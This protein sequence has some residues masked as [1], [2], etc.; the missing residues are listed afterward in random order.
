MN[1]RFTK[2]KENK[3]KYYYPDCMKPLLAV[4]YTQN[5]HDPMMTFELDRTFSWLDWRQAELVETRT[6][7]ATLMSEE[8][9]RLYL[10]I[11]PNGSSLMELL[12]KYDSSDR[13]QQKLVDPKTNL[14]NMFRAH[15]WGLTT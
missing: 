13:K 5:I 9:V 1:S 7:V 15:R 12:L 14:E 8:Q 3:E 4:D 11:F 2:S 6:D 10:S